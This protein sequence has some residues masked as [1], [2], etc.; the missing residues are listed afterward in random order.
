MTFSGFVP[1]LLTPE[2]SGALPDIVGDILSGYTKMTAARNLKPSLDE[3]LKKAKLANKHQMLANI[4]AQLANQYYEPNMKS[5]LALRNAQM[6]SA[7][8]NAQRARMIQALQGQLLGISPNSN[9]QEG[10]NNDVSNGLSDGQERQ[11]ENN[12]PSSAP[13]TQRTPEIG[14]ASSP[15]QYALTP[16][17]IQRLHQAMPDVVRPMVASQTSKTIPASNYGKVTTAMQMLG[18]GKPQIVQD[19]E[20]KYVAIT[21]FGNIDTGTS[22]LSE[23]GKALSKEDA[24]K[25]S[26]LENTALAGYQKQDTFDAMN[27]ILGSNEFEQLRQHPVAGRYELGYYEKL[28]TP[29]QQKMIGDLKAYM[30][31]I[32]KDAAQD[33]KGQFRVGEQ[34]LVNSMKPNPGDSLDVMKG[35]AEALTYMNQMMTK[36]AELESRYMRDYNISAIQAKV[37][38][39]KVIKPSEVKK[40]INSILYQSKKQ[41]SQSADMVTIR[42]KKTGETITVT[43]EEARKRGVGV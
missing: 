21:P 14:G 13:S 38:A 36:R 17:Q 9:Q 23:K 31:Q 41:T 30:G 18:L 15:E 33:F 29:E 32:I 35:K 43:R 34:A 3:E 5:Q 37:A 42:N 8:A 40:Q 7:Q 12:F 11:M 4:H 26:G 19:A 1:P 10:Q 20:G 25:I 24:K 22:T 16:D 2:Q 39:N 28:G 27:N 6:Q